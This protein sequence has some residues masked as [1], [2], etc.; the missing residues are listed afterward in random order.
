VRESWQLHSTATDLAT[1]VYAASS[2]QSWTE[3]PQALPP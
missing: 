1:V 2:R 3:M